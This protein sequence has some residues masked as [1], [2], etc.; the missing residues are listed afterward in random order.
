MLKIKKR[1]Y[2]FLIITGV[3]FLLLYFISI[4]VPEE[5][6]RKIVQ[7]L[8]P[9]GPIV[10]IL[11]FWLT[12]II[13]PLGATPF[14]FAGFYLYGQMIVIIAFTAAVLAMI[15]NYW[16][17]RI[18]GR[19]L[20]V[21]LAGSENLERID[22][23]TDSYGYQTLFIIRLFLKEFHDVVSYV[24]GL[25]KIKFI[26]YF[27]ISVIGMIPG[28][29]IWYYLSSLI[30]NPLIFTLLSIGI[31]NLFLITYLIWIKITKKEKKFSEPNK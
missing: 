24:F 8:D 10:L 29:I 6:I 13:A 11:L 31:A 25:T 1:S 19:S 28:T 26:P 12:N 4:Q 16:I 14:I 17:A 20:V 5:N 30:S 9:F 3:L 27:I 7:N 22:R 15:T 23:L 18:W 21:K 2:F